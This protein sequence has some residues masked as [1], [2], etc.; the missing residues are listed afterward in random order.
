[1]VAFSTPVSGTSVEGIVGGKGAL[2]IIAFSSVS[3]FSIVLPSGLVSIYLLSAVYSY[4]V[5]NIV[6]VP[7]LI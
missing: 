4:I 7:S 1:V 6:S 5:T 3:S 2:V